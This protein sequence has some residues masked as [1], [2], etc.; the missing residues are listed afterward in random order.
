MAK[1]VVLYQGQRAKIVLDL[2]LNETDQPAR[3]SA[4]SFASIF[5]MVG[6]S[7]VDLT[8]VEDGSVEL[9][10]W[11]EPAVPALPAVYQVVQSDSVHL[12]GAGPNGENVCRI[13]V[14][15]ADAFTLGGYLRKRHKLIAANYKILGSSDPTHLDLWSK[16]GF[17]DFVSQDT[18][19]QTVPAGAYS[20]ILSIDPDVYFGV[21]NSTGVISFVIEML[22]VS[23]VA[24]G[25]PYFDT[26]N[27]VAISVSLVLDTS[28]LTVNAG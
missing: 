15:N 16:E 4:I 13:E 22:D 9:S 26:P 19:E 6:D 2:Q 10:E 24:E 12:Q 23:R 18:V 27:Q 20:F 7:N 17:L 25:D 21:V 11:F 1:E 28:G 3:G 14:S 8:S 5:L